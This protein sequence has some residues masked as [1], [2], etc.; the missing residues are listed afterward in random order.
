VIGGAS[1]SRNQNAGEASVKSPTNFATMDGG[2][3]S[4]AEFF[5]VK[6]TK[7]SRRLAKKSKKSKKGLLQK[8]PERVKPEQILLPDT[9]TEEMD[10]E[11]N[12]PVEKA[13]REIARVTEKLKTK[14]ELEKLFEIEKQPERVRPDQILLPDT[15]AEETD[16]EAA[17]EEAR[18]EEDVRVAREKREQKRLGIHTEDGSPKRK[19]FVP[20][21]DQRPAKTTEAFDI[22]GDGVF[23]EV[24]VVLAHLNVKQAM[25]DLETLIIVTRKREREAEARVFTAQ[26]EYDAS[27]FTIEETNEQIKKAKIKRECLLDCEEQVK[28]IAGLM[29]AKAGKIADAVETLRS[30]EKGASAQRVD[31]L[32]IQKWPSKAFEDDRFAFLRAVDKQIL[33]DIGE[34][35]A[36]LDSLLQPFRRMKLHYRGLYTSAYIPLS[37]KE[38]VQM[39]IKLELLWWDPLHFVGDVVEQ[40]GG[41]RLI[42]DPAL[43]DF[44]WFKALCDYSLDDND[45]DTDLVPFMVVQEVFPIISHLVEIW[46]MQDARETQRL[47]AVIEEF[48]TFLEADDKP[49]RDLE[50]TLKQRVETLD[51]N[52]R[53]AA[54]LGENLSIFHGVFGEDF[55]QSLILECTKLE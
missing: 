52:Q 41:R 18:L 2:S 19:H 4:E 49:L 8:Q 15:D 50:K 45:P 42:Q 35:F 44:P 9:D 47:R 17:L 37:I 54:S 11:D 32:G 51:L 39:H 30:M 34:S 6:K 16:L 1:K 23:D 40:P 7:A 27:K 14:Q 24:P 13:Q 3:E 12:T 55:L 36:A 20:Q 43:D 48:A 29:E 31:E 46:D 21:P 33:K 53:E 38:V 25:D 22:M 10:I 28:N 5:H 26:D